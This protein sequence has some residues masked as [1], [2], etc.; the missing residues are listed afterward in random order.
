MSKGKERETPRLRRE[1][2]GGEM[3]M[4]EATRSFHC[5]AVE[6]NLTRIHEDLGSVPGLVQR[7]K[8]PMLP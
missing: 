7:V 6:M 4:K 2:P 8:D 1:E 3:G 5:G